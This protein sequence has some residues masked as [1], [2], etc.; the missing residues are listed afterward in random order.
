MRLF[1]GRLYARHIMR[2]WHC[3]LIPSHQWVIEVGHPMRIV[4]RTEV[5][6]IGERD[7]AV[8]IL[9]FGCDV[10]LYGGKNVLRPEVVVLFARMVHGGRQFGRV[11]CCEL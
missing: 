5:Q 2:N 6:A 9:L 10:K 3:L 7:I 11:H 4:I 1:L 8:R